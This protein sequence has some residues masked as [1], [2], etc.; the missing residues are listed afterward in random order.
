MDVNQL[1]KQII[2]TRKRIITHP[3]FKIKMTKEQIALFMTHHVYAVWSFMSIVKAL[4]R[5]ICPRNIPWTPNKNTSNGLARLINEIIFSEE[6]DEI[7]KGLYLSHFEMYRKAMRTIGVSTSKIDCIIDTINKKGYSRSL[8]S[9][10]KIPQSCKD[11]MINDISVAKSN[12]LAEIIGVFCIG[13]ETIIPSMFK[14]IVKSIP[15][16]NKLLTNYFHRH[17]DIDDNRHGPLAKRMLRVIT[18]TKMNE[19]RAY[20]SGLKSLE[21]RYKLWDELHMN[22]K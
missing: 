7:S 16:S 22:M 21:L 20:K 1:H 18:K 10:M 17:I 2:F 4:Q 19:N 3:L 8:L 12:N 14:Q 11:F 15:K 5:N 13:K 6:S 9:N